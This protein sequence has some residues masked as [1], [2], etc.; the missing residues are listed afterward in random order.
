M[1]I[2]DTIAEWL[3]DGRLLAAKRRSVQPGDIMILVRTRNEFVEHMIRA[4]RRRN[5]PVSG[6]DRMTL[7]HHLAVQ[8]VLSVMKFVLLPEDDLNLA[9]LLKSPFG[10]FHEPLLFS[11]AWNRGEVGLW[12][13]LRESG[14]PQAADMAAWL[15]RCRAVA[16]EKRPYDFL[17]WLLETDDGRAKLAARLGAEI[18]DPLEELLHQVRSYEETHAAALQGFVHW[19]EQR[20]VVIKRDQEAAGNQVRILTVHGAK[21]LQAPIIFLPDTSDVPTLKESLLWDVADGEPVCFWLPNAN[22]NHSVLVRVREQRHADI[23]REQSRLLYVALTRAEDELVIGG[24]EK[25]NKKG[26]DFT[27]YERIQRAHPA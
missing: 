4:L 20:D 8:D 27:W 11:L 26:R 9:C 7:S 19:F 22:I 18:F 1:Q 2:A 10:N 15:N 3:G 12:Q 25:R 21:G 6:L 14:E 17:I 16:L 13:R 24:W 23:L 5:I